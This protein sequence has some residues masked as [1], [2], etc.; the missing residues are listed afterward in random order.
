MA[1]TTTTPPI[2]GALQQGTP[3]M[4]TMPVT[5]TSAPPVGA[6]PQHGNSVPSGDENHKSLHHKGREKI[7]WGHEVWERSLR[8]ILALAGFYPASPVP[9]PV[10]ISSHSWARLTNI[11]G[12]VAGTTRLRDELT[13]LYRQDQIVSSVFAA[14][15]DWV[16]NGSAF[17]PDPPAPPVGLNFMLAFC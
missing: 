16:W 2:A 6:P 9:V 13:L 5:P 3:G 14:M 10:N 7:L 17:A 4:G 11:T 12:L 15:L 1:S 8:L